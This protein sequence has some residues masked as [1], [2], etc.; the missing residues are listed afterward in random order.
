MKV[1]KRLLTVCLC[2]S[3]FLLFTSCSAGDDEDTTAGTGEGFTM[4]ATVRAVGEKLEVEVT[5]G[6]YGASGP[7]WVNT[8]ESTLYF[9]K[10]GKKIA[11]GDLRPGDTVEIVYGGQVMMSYPPQIVASRVTVK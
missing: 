8:P 9:N 11:R 7:Y 4:T 3:L 5:E 1:Y 6:P 2:L 10:E